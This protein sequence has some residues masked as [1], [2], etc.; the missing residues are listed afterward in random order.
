MKMKKS[1]LIPAIIFSCFFACFE[2]GAQSNE[3]SNETGA[4]EAARLSDIT[5]TA[6]RRE[7]LLSDTAEVFQIITS[8]EIAEINPGDTGK[9]LEYVTGADVKTGTGSGLP[10][11]SVIGLNGLPPKYTL[12]LIDGV[13]LLGEHVHTGRNIERIPPQNIERIEIMRGAAAAQ[14]GTDAIGG[15]VNIVTKKCGTKESG[16]AYA[17]AASYDTYAGGISWYKPISKDLRFS[18]SFNREQSNG[19]EIEAPAHRIGNMGYEDNNVLARLDYKPSD[20]SRLYSWVNASDLKMDWLGEEEDAYLFTTASG[21][22]QR[23]SQKLN[24]HSKFAFSVWD[25][26]VANER[27]EL[28]QPEGWINWDASE[29]HFITAGIDYK[30]RE[31]ERNAVTNAPAQETYGVF[32]KDDWKWSGQTTFSPSLRYDDVEGSDSA[33]SPKLSLL[34]SPDL[35]ARLRASFSRGYHA[36]TPQEQYEVAAGHGGPHL[37]F[38]N[39]KLD[40]EY[41]TTYG[42]G[43]ELFPGEK[44]DL[45]IYGYYSNIDDMIVPIYEGP[46]SVDPE[47]NVWRRQNVDS[48]EIYGGEIEAR[49]RLTRNMRIDTGYSFSSQEGTKNDKHLEYDPGSSAYIKGVA[50]TPVSKNLRA[51]TFLGLKTEF[52]RSAWSWQTEGR[53][54]RTELDDYQDLSAGISLKYKGSKEIFFN[55]HNLLGQN[56]EALDDVLTRFEDDPIFRMGV[57]YLW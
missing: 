41:S 47:K 43:L 50:H 51:T 42:L 5:V 40:P 13:R 39:K 23:L 30:R 25:S 34:Y 20:S 31:F 1:S 19:R 27:H 21:W 57:R 12:V 17:S 48:V 54:P 7:T 32:V 33:L 56:I 3:E 46:W 37:R 8:S 15:V 29:S 44:I 24:M 6:T 10:N 45:M 26:D 55:G 35:P 11:R 53:D 18:I 38:G 9:L 28:L 22:D 2:S 36:P 49:F 52:D 14:Y 4:E 16:S